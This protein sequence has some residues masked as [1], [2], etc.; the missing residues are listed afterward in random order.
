MI[1][2]C[3]FRYRIVRKCRRFAVDKRGERKRFRGIGRRE[4]K[5]GPLDT[6]LPAHSVAFRVVYHVCPLRRT[7]GVPREKRGELR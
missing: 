7:T 4:E 6:R 5:I 1:S 3:R 2:T